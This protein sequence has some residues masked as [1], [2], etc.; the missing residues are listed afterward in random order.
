MVVVRA[1][2]LYMLSRIFAVTI[3]W[4]EGTPSKEEYALP[5]NTLLFNFLFIKTES[6]CAFVLSVSVYVNI[7]P[8]PFWNLVLKHVN[9]FSSV[10]YV[11]CSLFCWTS[12]VSWICGL[13]FYQFGH[14]CLLRWRERC[15][16]ECNNLGKRAHYWSRRRKAWSRK[17]LLD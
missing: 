17:R 6:I 7:F 4:L 12:C 13:R 9:L 5:F 1:A 14:S 15:V 10:R 8:F 3:R 2:F 16:S 11:R